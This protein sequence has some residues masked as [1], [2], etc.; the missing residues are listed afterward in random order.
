MNDNMQAK[1]KPI[2]VA[3]FYAIAFSFAQAAF[4]DETPSDVE[5]DSTGTTSSQSSSININTEV[6]NL[7]TGS[8]DGAALP[9]GSESLGF[10]QNPD[11]SSPNL[12]TVSTSSDDGNVVEP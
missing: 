6:N 9:S 10:D 4:A 8:V 5:V 12:P 3:L 1:L 7:S 11:N 2:S